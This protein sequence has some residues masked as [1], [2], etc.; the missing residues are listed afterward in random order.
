MVNVEEDCVGFGLPGLDDF[1]ICRG[2]EPSTRAHVAFISPNPEAVDA[3]YQA[4]LA[5]GG[6]SKRPPGLRP[7]YHAEY[8]G[9]YVWDPDGNNIEAVHHGSRQQ[10]YEQVRVAGPD[11]GFP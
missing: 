4:A 2:P 8:Y 10:V 5:A 7:E 1:G 9:A 6:R 11:S 3:F